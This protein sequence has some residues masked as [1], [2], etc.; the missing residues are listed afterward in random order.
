MNNLKNNLKNVLFLTGIMILI[1]GISII[2]QE[3]MAPHCYG[4][5]R[6]TREFIHEEMI[7]PARAME[8]NTEG[9]VRLSF[10]VQKDGTVTDVRVEE[11]V[12]PEIDQEAIRIFSKILWFPATQLGKPIVYK[13]HFEIKFKIKK[14]MKYTK[15]RGYEYF[16]Y[17]WEPIDSSNIVYERNKTD[18]Q[19]KPMF[20]EEIK[21]FP[22]FLAKNLEYPEA[23]FKGNVAG[24]V[25][26]LFVVETSGRV[27]N[28]QVINAVGGGCTEEAIRVLKLIKWIPGV[29]DHYAVRTFMPLEMTFDIAKKTVGGSIPS[30]GQIQ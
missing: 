4:G 3:I 9:T 11:R 29:K 23:A 7:Y 15:L 2:A 12:S 14:Y 20:S 22:T 10:I 17:P 25:K 13:H 5:N 6:L 8:S 28:I 27:S 18:R 30:P 1:P 21:N 26:L 19:P 24:T 16:S